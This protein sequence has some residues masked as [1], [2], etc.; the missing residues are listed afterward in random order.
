M[1]KF[2]SFMSEAIKQAK[3]ALEMNEVPVGAVII[4]SVTNQIIAKTHNKNISQIDPTAHAE[5]LALKEACLVKNSH[6]L[7]NCDLYV[8]VEPCPM[9]A[10]AISLARIRRV[11]YGIE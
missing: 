8:T 4:D 10:G 6:R 7:D 5:I 3:I 2:N 11:Y 9:C 1:S